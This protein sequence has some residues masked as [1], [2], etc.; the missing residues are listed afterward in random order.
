MLWSTLTSHHHLT[1]DARDPVP[2]LHQYW[3]KLSE[4]ILKRLPPALRPVPQLPRP[5]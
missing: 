3:K 4:V 2:T 5:R 1:W